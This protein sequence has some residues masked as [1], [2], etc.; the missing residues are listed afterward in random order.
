MK[1]FQW[2]LVGCGLVV[3]WATKS[4]AS[5]TDV[6]DEGVASFYGPGFDGK[7]TASGEVFDQ[8]DLTAAHRTLPFGTRLRVT[9]VEN[10]RSVVVRINDRG[11]FTKQ[12]GVF[13]RSID[14]SVGAAQAIGLDLQRGLTRVRMERL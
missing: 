6:F 9:D 8:N 12:A 5:S 2:F 13:A 10:G 14:L 11:P 3:L 4:K 7:L 1:T